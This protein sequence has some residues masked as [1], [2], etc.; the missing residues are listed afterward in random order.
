METIKN[1]LSRIKL[2]IDEL[3]ENP[4][5]VYRYEQLLGDYG[6][7]ESLKLHLGTKGLYKPSKSCGEYWDDGY[8]HGVEF[9][10]DQIHNLIKYTVMD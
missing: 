9:M 3:I 2:L 6:Y 8:R 4:E 7:I 5:D 10:R 1:S